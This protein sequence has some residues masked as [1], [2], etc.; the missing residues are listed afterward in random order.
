MSTELI[1]AAFN[2][3]AKGVAVCQSAQIEYIGD[4]QV[5]TITGLIGSKPFT[6][7]TEPFKKGHPVPPGLVKEVLRF[8]KL[9]TVLDDEVST[10]NMLT[11]EP[12][13][14]KRMN[15]NRTGLRDALAVLK[16]KA[17]AA[18]QRSM[19][20]GEK[21]N[22]A[23]ERQQAAIDSLNQYA[24]EVTRESDDVLAELGQFGNGGP[25]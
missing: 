12:M 9:E 16:E 22:E 18:R 17:R 7:R 15:T 4:S 23:F 20:A 8:K 25:E 6:H 19:E 2:A 3:E 13:A 11:H 14:I 10:I 1:K 5:L 21:A 24:D